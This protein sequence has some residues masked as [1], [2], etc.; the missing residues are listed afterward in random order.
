MFPW[1]VGSHGNLERLESAKSNR[2]A[3]KAK[4]KLHT[5]SNYSSSSSSS[6]PSNL[7]EVC[8]VVLICLLSEIR[9]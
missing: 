1:F 9:D 2:R 8:V 7:V 3:L 6:R 5:S 4:T